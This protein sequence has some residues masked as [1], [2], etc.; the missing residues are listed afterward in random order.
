[1]TEQ[2]NQNSR[3]KLIVVGSGDNR[4]KWANSLCNELFGLE[5]RGEARHIIQ[6]VILNGQTRRLVPRS[7]SSTTISTPFRSKCG[8]RFNMFLLE[9][10]DHSIHCIM[11]LVPLRRWMQGD[12]G[13]VMSPQGVAVITV[14]PL[15]GRS[16]LDQNRGDVWLG[17]DSKVGHCL[18]R[19]L[20]STHQRRRRHCRLGE[21]GV[22]VK[23]HQGRRGVGTFLVNNRF[24]G[25]TLSYHDHLEWKDAKTWASKKSWP[26][27][28]K[29]PTGLVSIIEKDLQRPFWP[30]LE[31]EWPKPRHFP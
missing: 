27:F 14:G 23:L 9:V 18:W 10:V 19:W 22:F 1:M 12:D 25:S 30:Q 13:K 16:F 4:T 15:A 24:K 11:K 29:K 28:S 7:C 26:L 8:L 21:V 3:F 5:C 6:Q 31:K 20:R 17:V 2:T